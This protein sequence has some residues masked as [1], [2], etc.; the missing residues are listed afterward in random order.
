MDG[1]D[2][3]RRGSLLDPLMSPVPLEIFS[4]RLALGKSQDRRPWLVLEVALDRR[5][6]CLQGELKRE[7]VA[8]IG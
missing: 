4:A 6:G 7:F 8:W 1:G 2:S 3:D 5:L